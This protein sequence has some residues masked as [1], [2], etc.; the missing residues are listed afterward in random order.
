MR[1]AGAIPVGAPPRVACIKLKINPGQT[2][3][4]TMATSSET[5]SL[6]ASGP[7]LASY[8][9]TT[10][11]LDEM[12]SQD[13]LHRQKLALVILGEVHHFLLVGF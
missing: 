12:S 6:V 5:D 11:E 4:C 13:A 8:S 9:G 7:P 10:N 2:N 1:V 3:R